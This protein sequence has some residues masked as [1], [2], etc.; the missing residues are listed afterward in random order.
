MLNIKGYCDN[1]RNTQM[2]VFGPGS[3]STKEAG[4]WEW[5]QQ[6]CNWVIL[7]ATA[8]TPQPQSDKTIHWFSL[9]VG[10]G[11]GQEPQH[12]LAHTFWPELHLYLYLPIVNQ[13]KKLIRTG[14]APRMK[15]SVLH[16]H[17]NISF[18]FASCPVLSLYLFTPAPDCHDIILAV[19]YAHTHRDLLL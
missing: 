14:T 1:F 11:R 4:W 10:Q 7:T 9:V 6:A 12:T 19:A 3:S 18:A 17:F 13:S 2:Q 15:S 5:W 16:S 8:L